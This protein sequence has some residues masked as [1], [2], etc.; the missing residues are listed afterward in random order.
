MNDNIKI[1]FPGS[2]KTYLAGNLYPDLKVAM[3]RVT[4]TPTVTID[5]DGKES[6]QDNGSVLIYD[7]SGPYGDDDSVIDLRKGLPRLR[8]PWNVAVWSNWPN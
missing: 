3:R 6:R 1:T 4:L 8:E 2:K 5:A 7:T